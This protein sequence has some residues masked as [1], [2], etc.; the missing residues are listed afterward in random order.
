MTAR[1][2]NLL[3]NSSVATPCLV[4]DQQR[5][6]INY[7]AFRRHMPKM[8]PYYAVKANHIRLF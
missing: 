1:I 6:A 4:L 7:L 5:V 3:A 2:E 8:T